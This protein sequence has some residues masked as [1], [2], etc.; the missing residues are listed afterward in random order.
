MSYSAT[1]RDLFLKRYESGASN[2]RQAWNAMPVEARQWRPAEGKWSAHEVVG[3]CAD[4]ETYSAIRIRLLLAEQEALIVGYDENAWA[5][6]FNYHSVDPEFALKLIDQVRAYTAVMLRTLPEDAW[7]K[8]GRHSH[9]GS[10][11][12]DDWL[13]IYAE[14]LEVHTAQI[15]RNRAAWLAQAR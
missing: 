5:K 4:S 2:L 9:S 1:E 12:T 3:H 13:R 6:R 10:Y 14:H 15:E 8:V 11:G 7:G